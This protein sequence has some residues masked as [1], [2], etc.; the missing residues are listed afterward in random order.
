MPARAKW[1]QRLDLFPVVHDLLYRPRA[2]V[3]L[4]TELGN[5]VRAAVLAGAG[6]VGVPL[7]ESIT[8]ALVAA[9]RAVGTGKRWAHSSTK[10]S[11]AN[12]K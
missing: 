5:D 9:V 6:Q 7:V 4:L 8:Q 11:T 1:T 10:A 12:E 3:V 2:Q